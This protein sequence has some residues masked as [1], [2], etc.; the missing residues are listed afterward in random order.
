MNIQVRY[1]S[2]SGN[3][4]SLAQAI[5]KGVNTDAVSIDK[6][7]ALI[8]EK[9][10]CLFIGGALYMYGL[11]NKLKKYIANLN[12][13]NINKAVVFS[14]SWISKHSIELLKKELTDKG[15]KVEEEYFYA[16][17]KPTDEELKKAEDFAKSFIA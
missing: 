17:N 12:P 10:D 3:T 6:I 15:I 4:K 16:K 2:R 13:E 8:N 1:Y 7:G 9:V 11:D 5:A 14:T